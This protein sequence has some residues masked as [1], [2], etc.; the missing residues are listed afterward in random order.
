MDLVV[1]G[2]ENMPE[3]RTAQMILF[4]LAALLLWSCQ[5]NRQGEGFWLPILEPTS[6]NYLEKTVANGLARIDEADAD[7]KSGNNEQAQE[8]LQKGRRALLELRHYFVPMTQARQLIYDADRLY[9]LNRTEASQRN[10]NQAK[11]ILIGLSNSNN[12]SLKN[13]TDEVEVLIDRLLLSIK[14]PSSDIS[15]LFESLGHKVNMLTI[16]GD[17]V[18]SGVRFSE[19]P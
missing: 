7:L 14:D 13:A 3:K 2:K 8:N 11:E 5:Q 6:F 9:V 10:L 16:K 19:E 18:L 17:L 12:G 1:A 4:C 15:A